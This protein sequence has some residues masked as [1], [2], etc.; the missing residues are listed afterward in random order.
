VKKGIAFNT[1]RNTKSDILILELDLITQLTKKIKKIK[2]IGINMR[3]L[4]MAF[5]ILD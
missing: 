1:T 2:N 3:F 4:P 5:M